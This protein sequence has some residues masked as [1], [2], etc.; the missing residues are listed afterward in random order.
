MRGEKAGI[1]MAEALLEF[2][3]MMYNVNTSKRVIKA[4]IN[5]LNKN[6][7]EFKPV[8]QKILKG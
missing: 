7:K 6:L 4:M 5:H 8:K 3:H 1:A 2:C